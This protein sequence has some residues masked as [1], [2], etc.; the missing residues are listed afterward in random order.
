MGVKCL[1]FYS[2]VQAGTL[3]PCLILQ[4]NCLQRWIVPETLTLQVTPEHA[5]VHSMLKSLVQVL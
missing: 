4:L 5:V 1:I 2:E 3:I